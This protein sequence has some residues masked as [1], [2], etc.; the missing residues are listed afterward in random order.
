M[1]HTVTVVI[2]LDPG[3]FWLD[4]TVKRHLTN[5]GANPHL[6]SDSCMDQMCQYTFRLNL[7]LLLVPCHAHGDAYWVRNTHTWENRICVAVYDAHWRK[8][9]ERPDNA[10]DLLH[11]DASEP[12]DN[13]GNV[14]VTCCSS[15]PPP[16][17]SPLT[18]HDTE[19]WI[20][21][22]AVF[23]SMSH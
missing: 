9:R 23:P 3:E 12:Q 10:L 13:R 7:L 17:P 21:V 16:P 18:N 1:R 19:V 8:G 2:H 14:S 11:R 20:V 4:G 15:P 22:P 6:W 5:K